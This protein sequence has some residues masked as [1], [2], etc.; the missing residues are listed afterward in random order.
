[1]EKQVYQ[2]LLAQPEWQNKRKAILERDGNRCRNCGSMEHL[3]VHHRQYHIDKAN[4]SKVVPWNYEDQYLITL[5][6]HCHQ[7]GHQKYQIPVFI[8][9]L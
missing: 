3:E 2:Y 5:C 6:D 7:L 9:N 1:M 8:V 4:G